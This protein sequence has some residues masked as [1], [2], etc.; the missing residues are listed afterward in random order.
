M[1]PAE[2]TQQ[3]RRHN[4]LH[5]L[6]LCVK[7]G[8]FRSVWTSLDCVALKCSRVAVFLS[9]TVAIQLV[10]VLRVAAAR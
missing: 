1:N 6:N 9:A 3:V 10:S 8:V 5:K 4:L 7:S 2:R